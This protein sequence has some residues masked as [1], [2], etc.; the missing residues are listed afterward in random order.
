MSNVETPDTPAQTKF[1]LG[2]AV[3]D[4]MKFL[5]Q[6]VLP[7]LSTL[8]FTLSGVWDLP[9]TTQ[10]IGTLAALATFFGVLLGIST[11][12]YNASDAKFDGVIAIGTSDTGA[13]LYSLELKGDP[14]DL[15]QKG[16]VLFKIGSQ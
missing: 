13:K 10:V 12:Q 8:Y 15:D 7:A 5:V 14:N 9:Y 11:K 6:T 2:D 1:I 4:K 16:S 3:Y